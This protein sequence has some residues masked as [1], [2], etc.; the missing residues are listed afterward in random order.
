LS[1]SKKDI[2]QTYGINVLAAHRPYHRPS[3]FPSIR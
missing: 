1:G 3:A 2:C